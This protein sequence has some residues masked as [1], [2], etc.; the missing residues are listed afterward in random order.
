VSLRDL[1]T[2][3][4]KQILE[5]AMKNADMNPLESEVENTHHLLT[6]ESVSSGN[7]T[8]TVRKLEHH[9]I[10]VGE[11]ESDFVS[12]Q[13]VRTYLRDCRG[14]EH[15]RKTDAERIEGV[16]ESLTQLQN[17]ATTVTTEKLAQLD[18]TDRID[19]GDFRVF[20]DMRVFCEDCEKQYEVSEILD[21]RGCKCTDATRSSDDRTTSS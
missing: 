16:A 7:R 1:A 10:D 13:A 2:H 11:L 5:V 18:R 4:N 19:L 20:L 12:Y 17:R 6:D 8:E 14:V 21:R 9:G 15:T 3:F